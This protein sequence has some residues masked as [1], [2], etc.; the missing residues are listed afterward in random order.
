[1]T[2]QKVAIEDIRIGERAR[3]DMGDLQGL[4]N[5]I[6]QFGLIHPIVVTPDLQLI[7]GQRRLEAC[8]RLRLKQ[9]DVHVM[10]VQAIARGQHDENAYREPLLPTEQVAAGEAVEE[11]IR[12][13][14]KER[15]RAGNRRGGKKRSSANELSISA[16]VSSDSD[17]TSSEIENS[18]NGEVATDGRSRTDEQAARGVGARKDRYRQQKEIVQ[19]ARDHPQWYGDL[20]ELMDTKGKVDPVYKKLKEREEVVKTAQEI[21]R[22]IGLLE[23]LEDPLKRDEAYHEMHR[24]MLPAEPDP[25]VAEDLSKCSDKI[26][27]ALGCMEAKWG[28]PQILVR[29]LTYGERNA[30]NNILRGIER[31]LQA[32]RKAFEEFKEAKKG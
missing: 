4:A 12:R 23:I 8:K 15:Q 29:R 20:P 22:L 10:D 5:S 27:D 30:F 16:E 21:P 9:I 24:R 18:S 17:E 31:K 14:T 32:W 2:V 19:A 3:K 1:M 6:L 11:E 13:L 7:A 26:H 25:D 28:E